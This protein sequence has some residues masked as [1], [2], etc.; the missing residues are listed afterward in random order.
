LSFGEI[1]GLVAGAITTGSFVPQ[2]VRVYKIKSAREISLFFTILFL[3]G[4]ILWMLYGIYKDSIS[5]ILWNILGASM[6]AALLI[7]K[8][9]YGKTTVSKEDIKADKAG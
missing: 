4:D 6:A 7:G 9:K 8:V 2:V 5:I 1:L 3:V